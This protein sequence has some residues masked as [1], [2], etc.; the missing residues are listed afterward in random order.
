[1]NI[2]IVLY[3]FYQILRIIWSRAMSIERASGSRFGLHWAA[4]YHIV[5]VLD[6]TYAWT[7]GGR[8]CTWSSVL[9]LILWILNLGT[10]KKLFNII[11]VFA[12]GIVIVLTGMLFSCLPIDSCICSF[13]SMLVSWSCLSPS[14]HAR[15]IISVIYAWSG[16]AIQM[17]SCIKTSSIYLCICDN[18]HVSTFVN[19]SFGNWTI[20]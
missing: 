17:L 5:D 2:W 20:V 16:N 4:V 3:S 14:V 15:P 12:L 7:S 1:M 6:M 18:R 19:G 9:T 8:W 10:M 11:W 13:N